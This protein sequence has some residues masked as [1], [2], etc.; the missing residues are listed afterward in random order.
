MRR[1]QQLCI[2]VACDQCV[3]QLACDCCHTLLVLA[4]LLEH[5]SVLGTQRCVLRLE[6]AKSIPFTA[7]VS[8]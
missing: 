1:E 2:V 6:V 3:C 7:A 4:S 8:L 5:M